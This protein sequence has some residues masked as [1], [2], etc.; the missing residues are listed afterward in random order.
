[1][2]EQ[3]PYSKITLPTTPRSGLTICLTNC[4]DRLWIKR[5]PPAKAESM[6]TG[7]LVER[8]RHI[9]KLRKIKKEGHL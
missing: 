3:G 2:F 8:Q 6:F 1:M 4:R 7:A 5:V 9:R